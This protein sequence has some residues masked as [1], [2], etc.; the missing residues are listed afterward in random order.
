[1]NWTLLGIAPTK[2]KKAITAAYRAQLVHTN[3][4]D[5]P[6]EFKALRAAYE[7]ALQLA[8]QA[9]TAPARDES[10]VGLWME[11]VR[12]LYDDFAR[13]IQPENWVE[14]L[15]DDVCAALDT[16][17]LA[18][19][20]LLNFLTQD[21][22]IPQSVWQ[23]LDRAFGWVERREELYESY[24]RD[25]VDYA[26]MNGIR[27]PGNLPYELFTPGVSGKDCDE[28][29]RLY[30]RANQ[31]A[32]EEMAPLLQQ[33]DKLSERH[34]YGELLT[35]WLLLENGETQQGLDGYRQ[36]AEAYPQDAKLQLEWAAQCMKLEN[37][38]EGEI[39]TR[40][41]LALAPDAA[42]A[43]Q[44][45]A[46]CL[47]NQGQ[48]EDAK[49]LLFQLMDAA[50]GDQKRIY[51]L[52]QMVQAWNENLMQS[53]ETQLQA[54]PENME[55]R[56]KLAWCYLQ[57]DRAEEALQL[58][59]GIDPAYEDQYDYH[60]L[61]A[62]TAYSLGDY[63]EA[64]AHLQ[65]TEELLRVMQPD[66]TEQTATR[67]GSLP[68]KL[69]MQG[70]CLMSMGRTEEAVQKYEQALALAPEDAEVLTHMGH[71]L[72]SLGNYDR[73]A[74]IFE[75]VTDVLPS[76]YHGF[77][78]LA[79]TLYDLGRDRDA[80]AA[81]NRALELEGGDLGVYLLKMR[82]LLRN[83]AW[84]GVRST[85][86]FLHQHGITDEINTLWCEAQLLEQG[87]GNKE[88]A[89]EL[90]R[91]LAARVENGEP[92]EEASRLYFRLLVRE[93]EHLDAGKSEDRAKMLALAEKG[94]SHD[95]N[96]LPCLDYK[97]W[98]LKRDGKRE[99]A[100]TIYHRLEKFSRRSMSVEEEL[101]EIYYQDLDHDADKA[102]HY[103]QML[104]END[105]QPAYLFYAGTCC[106]Y[107][108]DYAEAERYF[109][110][111]QEVNPDGVDGYNGM[112]YL[113]D[114]M[115]R[116]EEALEQVDK[117]IERAQS[118]EGDQSGYYYHKVRILRRLNRPL[119]AMA[120]T[121]EVTAKY[122]NDDVFQEKFD[123]C[124][125]FGLWEQAE[126]ILQAWR[127]DGSRK[128]RLHAAT[129]DLALF[130]G[131]IDEARAMLQSAS[132]KLNAGDLERFTLLLG[133]LDGD[134]AAQM[135]I[136]EK[137]V[138]NRQDKTHELMNMAQVQWWSGHYDEA[139]A[140]AQEALVQLEELIPCR[141]KSEALYR[142]RRCLVL[143]ILG[144]FEEAVAE[145][146]A[147]RQLPLCESCSYCACKDADIFEANIEEI[148]GNWTRA[149]ALHR[150]GAERWHDDMDFVS[151][152][153][154]MMRKGLDD[155]NR[156]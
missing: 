4:E 130:S 127:K 3:P 95:E 113:Y 51:E 133:E 6:E 30:Y 118:R 46:T 114:T 19:A 24:A 106:K 75:K 70:S 57:N 109:L 101:A 66:G 7:E 13:R 89:L 64:L 86:D 44:M 21:F 84:E 37:W 12:A 81:V 151:G 43:K 83:G 35:Y 107:L 41:T 68:E 65:A 76:A 80:F 148:R 48:Y 52:R 140:Y 119:E 135:P 115:K 26:V 50:G 103:Y 149:L 78:L 34:P 49:K 117:V 87:E 1:M 45:L 59:R 128:N 42:Q 23:T 39:Y 102:L 22:Y 9:E 98:L 47:A 144:R 40:R 92:L 18:E 104:L 31:S 154:R 155:D 100:L 156:Y 58:C 126:Q 94:L 67:I 138:A 141:K 20:A 88:Q 145:L 82:I 36:L 96:D 73:A 121:D 99:E 152:A 150:A 60:N 105:E 143:A 29:R 27:Y 69:Q 8:D 11:R 134:E 28:Y 2:D 110:R 90:Y 112:S 17:P 14:L 71:L 74:E 111:L 137:R 142:S 53:L 139:R 33:M 136:W 55:L 63:A 5:K 16:R 123:I 56:L 93:A 10:P 120:V 25:F 91:A 147:V 116:Y 129:I 124:C 79:Q 61:Y 131:K 54:A 108:G 97:A 38:A 146:E 132:G 77:Y 32:P 122:G 85:L 15:S 125:Q 153:R 62:K 72:R